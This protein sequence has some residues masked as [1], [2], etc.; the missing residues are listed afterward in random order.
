VSNKFLDQKPFVEQAI[1]GTRL[2]AEYCGRCTDNDW[3]LY[4][5]KVNDSLEKFERKVALLEHGR[6]PHCGATR[7]QLFRKNKINPYIE[8]ALSAGQRCVVADTMMLTQDG[9]IEIGDYAGNRPYGFSDFNID[10]STGD[11]VERTSKFY[12]AKEEHCKHVKTKLGFE[13]VGTVDHPV[14]TSSGFK[15]LKDVS[16]GD[17]VRVYYGQNMFGNKS[18]ILRDV[19]ERADNAFAIYLDSLDTHHANMVHKP[20]RKPGC[21]KSNVYELTTDLA[22]VVGYWVAEGR[23][24]GIAND[25]QNVLDLCFNVLHSMF[26]DLVRRK[27]RGVEFTSKYVQIWLQTFMQVDI[28]AGSSGK[29]VPKIILQGTKEIQCAFLSALFEGDGGV[30]KAKLKNRYSVGYA[31]I[32]KKLVDQI[33]VM[34]LNLGIPHRRR[35]RPTWATNGSAKQVEKTAYCL[36]ITGPAIVTFSDTIGFQSER[37]SRS[38]NAA[39]E[40]YERSRQ[41]NVPSYYEQLPTSLREEFY[42]VFDELQAALNTLP[43]RGTKAQH[44]GMLQ[45]QPAQFDIIAQLQSDLEFIAKDRQNITKGSAAID[46]KLQ[47]LEGVYLKT[48]Y[49]LKN[50]S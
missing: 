18:V 34:L 31:S 15:C 35:E 39:V 17:E 28:K 45:G 19:T 5:H 36:S 43:L 41:N 20:R 3:L 6:C 27:S 30:H 22:K 46:N 21:G 14:M 16:V 44:V 4:D 50:L 48:L 32:S 13:V 7:L 38:L 47:E 37:K 25:D 23:H 24:R 40:F 29:V 1:V 11:S 33:S 2:F 26:G 8:L 9:I 12:R 42:Q 10:V 49:K